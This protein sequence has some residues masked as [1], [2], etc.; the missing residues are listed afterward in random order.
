[1]I[2]LLKRLP[3]Y[4]LALMASYAAY[5]M[6]PETN[7][8]AF[9]ACAVAI[10]YGVFGL[11]GGQEVADGIVKGVVDDLLDFVPLAMVNI[12]IFQIMGKPYAFV[13]ALFVIPLI[14]DLIA[15]LFG[16]E[17]DDAATQTLKHVSNLANVVSLLHLSYMEDNYMFGYVALSYLSAHMGMVIGG[18]C[19]GYV[20]DLNYVMS[21]VLFYFTSTLAV[22]VPNA[23]K[24]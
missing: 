11:V 1:M 7:P 8:Y 18:R 21:Y 17:S 2:W 19:H 23:P 14:L 3:F 24:A 9:T 6:P 15:K 22:T 10:I 12:E 13:H 20:V 4:S 16:E 5:N